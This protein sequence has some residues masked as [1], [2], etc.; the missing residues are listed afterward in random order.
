L[1]SSQRQELAVSALSG[2]QPVVKIAKQHEVSRKF[3]YTQSAKAQQALDEAFCQTAPDDKV[4]FY[5]PVTK[6]W[7]RQLVL[8]LILICHSSLR[9]VVELLRDLFQTNISVGGVHNIVAEAIDKARQHNEQQ[10]LSAVRIGAHDEIFQHGQPVLA[11]ADVDSTFC[12]LL[13]LDEQRD[14][15]TWALHLLDLQQRGFMPEA[16]I[17]DAGQGIRKGQKL[18]MADVPCRGDVFHALKMVTELAVYLEN[19]A[20]DAISTRDK[21]EQ[22]QAQHERRQGRRDLKLS[23]QISRARLTEQQAICLADEV[24]ILSQWL[25]ADIF[26]VAGP[27]FSDRC[28]LYDYIVQELRARQQ[29]CQHRIGK[30]ATA[31][32]NQ[33]DDLLAFAKQL[34]RDLQTLSDE[35]EIS[36]TVARRVLQ[37]Q[38]LDPKC[39]RRWQEH[40]RLQEQLGGR[41][42]HLSEA[43]ADVARQTVRASSIIENFNSRLRSYFFLRRHLGPGYLHLLQFFLNHRRFLRSEQP[44]RVNKSPAELLNGRAHPH[45]LEMLGY[46][47]FSRN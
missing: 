4:L 28:V 21:L 39:S 7:L 25:Q 29:L 22:K 12:Y 5:L 34:D 30:V 17:A 15:E 18:A 24:A 27:S 31:L 19:R 11:G 2:E 1:D 13:S 26:A 44:Q 23:Q 46:Q 9:G 36:P 6:A 37:M 32:T 41:F 16:T 45:W 3:V 38:A 47:L 43:I 14:G 35:F 40:S 20:Y 42:Y 10:D 8:A 33:R